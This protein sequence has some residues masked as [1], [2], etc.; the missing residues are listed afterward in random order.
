MLNSLRVKSPVTCCSFILSV[1]H[2][3]LSNVNH[4]QQLQQKRPQNLIMRLFADKI[5]SF[6]FELKIEDYFFTSWAQ[7]N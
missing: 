3:Q 1:V 7:M 2:K 6:F 4:P 5:Y